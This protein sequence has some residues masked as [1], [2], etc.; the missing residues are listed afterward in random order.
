MHLCNNPI[1][2]IDYV[3]QILHLPVLSPDHV[4]QLAYPLVSDPYLLVYFPHLR[5]EIVENLPLI[6]QHT[7]LL[8]DLPVT[9]VHVGLDPRDLLLRAYH[10]L[11]AARDIPDIV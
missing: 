4:L 3:D 6:I 11:V 2:L 10:R 5:P 7:S 1:L 9:E 8:R